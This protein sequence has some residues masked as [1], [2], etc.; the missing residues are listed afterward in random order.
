MKHVALLAGVLAAG[1]S[2]D[3]IPSFPTY[4]ECFDSRPFADP[5]IDK[6]LI[7]CLDV[8]INGE[9]YACGE[10]RA[11]CIN[12]LT[13]NLNQFNASTVEV[14]DACTQYEDM[15]PPMPGDA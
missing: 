15:L 12:Y 11:G 14:Q 2:S 10:S 5:P 7:C 3:E 6:I 8:T 1:C 4:Q 9:R 13:N